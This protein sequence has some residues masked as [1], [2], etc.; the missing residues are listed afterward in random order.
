MGKHTVH[1]ADSRGHANNGWLDT[2]QTFS[3]ADYYDPERVHF[4]M[5]RVLND[6]VVYPGKGFGTHPH[7]N[8]EI[9][10]ITL[11]GDLEHRDSIGNVVEVKKGDIQVM[12]AGTGI[13]HSEYNKSED[14]SVNFLQ[15][16]VFP[17]EQNLAPRYGQMKLDEKRM[18]NA[19]LQIVSPDPTDEGAWIN[20]DA[21]FYLGSIEKGKELG[22]ILH[23]N[24]DGVYVFVIGG[25]V[26]A[27]GVALGERDGMGI[28]DMDKF[29]IRAVHD[30]EVLLIEV[31]MF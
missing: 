28:V 7:D 22:Y 20:Q 8:M 16:W 31:P 9:I 25:E 29:S 5:L 3:F 26:V 19:L 15:I 1:R 13:S 24:G 17:R 21:W 4:G 30:A 11:D 10:S 12:S 14:R 27:D 2:H 23:Q 18:H 6:D